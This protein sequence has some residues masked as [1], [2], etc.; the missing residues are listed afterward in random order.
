MMRLWVVVFCWMSKLGI[1]T[2][3]AF[4]S[5]ALGNLLQARKRV[6]Q[7]N[8]RRRL[9]HRSLLSI[10]TYSH[11]HTIY[12]YLYTHTPVIPPVI[13]SLKSWV[14]SHGTINPT[15]TLCPAPCAMFLHLGVLVLADLAEGGLVGSRWQRVPTGAVEPQ[16]WLKMQMTLCL[17]CTR[18]YYVLVFVCHLRL[19]IWSVPPGV[20][21]GRKH[22]GFV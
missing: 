4:G 22:C 5:E 8:Q 12:I 16:G 15:H 3:V 20:F 17:A 11:P 10:H 21:V 1:L 19:H 13:P 14:L 2:M 18:A 6:K 7:P 9:H